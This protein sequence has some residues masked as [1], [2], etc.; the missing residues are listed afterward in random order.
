LGLALKRCVIKKII[1]KFYFTWI[2]LKNLVKK[3]N[4]YIMIFIITREIDA[5][6]IYL[7][8]KYNICLRFYALRNMPCTI[9]FIIERQIDQFASGESMI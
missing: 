4:D 8:R 9:F 5:T 7:T 2:I 3:H 1:I 6:E